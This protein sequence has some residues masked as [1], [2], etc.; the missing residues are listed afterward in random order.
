MFR[1]LA[2]VLLG[3][4]ARLLAPFAATAATERAAFDA[5]LRA[6]LCLPSGTGMTE[7][8]QARVIDLIRSCARP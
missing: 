3:L 1:A 5:G 8:D 7:G 6:S 4:F 2:L